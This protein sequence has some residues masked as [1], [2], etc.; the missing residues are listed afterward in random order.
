MRKSIGAKLIA[1][2]V[3]VAG[4]VL[5]AGIT[6]IFGV[7]FV[8]EQGDVVAK[9]KMPLADM[10]MEMQIQM[11][12]GE[13]VIHELLEAVSEQQASESEKEWKETVS[14]HE[15]MRGAML[16][17]GKI[18]Y[19]EVA[20]LRNEE[21]RQLVE[22]AE[23]AHGKYQAAGKQLIN[24]KFEALRAIA[25]K[26]AAIGEME[27]EFRKIDEV[28]LETEELAEEW[29]DNKSSSIIDPEK[30][31]TK[32]APIGHMAMEM[33]ITLH[34]GR[35]LL[36][37]FARS[38]D[39]G[40]LGELEAQ[41]LAAN[42]SF[43]LMVESMLHGGKIGHV[44][45]LPVENHEV[46]E[47]VEKVRSRFENYKVAAVELMDKH[48]VNLAR[49]REALDNIGLM[50]EQAHQAGELLADVE[51]ASSV[52]V[53]DAV[54]VSEG[55]RSW[56]TSL[57][58]IL[59][60]LAFVGAIAI[61]L[62]LSRGITKGI[63]MLVGLSKKVSK[64]EVPDKVEVTY[65]D[66]IGQL[67]IAFNDLIEYF[68]EMSEAAQRIAEGDL[69]ADVVPRSS[70][71][72]L[73]TSFVAMTDSLQKLVGKVQEGAEQVAAAS[74]QISSG[75]Q[76]TA[77]GAQQ[78]AAGAEKQSSVVQQTSASVQQMNASIQQVSSSTQEQNATMQSVT[79]VVEGMT[80]SLQ[81]VAQSARDVAQAAQQMAQEAREGGTSIGQNLDSI[82]QIGKSSEKIG[83]IIA[84]I[85]DISEQIN[86]LALNAAIEAARAGEHGR[87]FAVVA[88]GVT[89]L[90]ERSQEAAKE[91]AAVIKETSAT[92][93]E[94]IKISD[95]AGDAMNKIVGS[96]ENV[97]GLIQS[98]SDAT[99]QQASG[100]EQVRSSIEEL[101]RMA[102]Q[103]SQAAE[104][105]A[106]S[107]NELVRGV[108]V[109]TEISQQNASVAE[110]SSTQAEEASSAAEEMVAQSQALQQ[111]ASVF[112]TLN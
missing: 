2:F 73:G 106:T 88:E 78:I 105:Q 65:K 102:T 60:V 53:R 84:V 48:R 61:G 99:V 69:T 25:A 3:G 54:A 19:V 71:D 52:E 82:K 20:P 57:L 33:R 96:V 85:T 110:E 38:E 77:Q 13:H 31:L 44:E 104:Q 43:D 63:A 70:Q 103:I 97:N 16:Q 56:T 64:G 98:I 59:T 1:G 24:N 26:N 58:V 111:A 80:S 107:S 27:A 95:K 37:E 41:L 75:S 76:S 45:L 10:S 72:A 5:V 46:R 17:G 15:K 39:E 11:A 83:E 35:V 108:N 109:L 91:I 12:T 92:I 14:E 30:L 22:Q 93:E 8:G 21:L 62:L 68:R 7:T 66:E 6:G 34:E 100:S 32:I 18:G 23:E 42:D 94:G 90:A 74:E 67:S 9:E 36:E 112:R 40:R 86:L 47:L 87:G 49:Q 101:N 51:E 89:K 29:M 50:E 81:D 79:S 55:T 4:L 28:S